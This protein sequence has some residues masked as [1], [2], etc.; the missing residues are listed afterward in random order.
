MAV[1]VIIL[2]TIVVLVALLL[3]GLILIQPSKSGGI[4]AA[5]GGIGESVFG[6]QAG[7]HLTKATVVLTTVFFVLALTLATMIGRGVQK[8]ET[9]R[10]IDADLR[11]KS[12]ESAQKPDEAAVAAGA[13]KASEPVT[14]GGAAGDKTE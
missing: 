13:E 11:L 1:L 6:A 5:F 14:A 3:I 12:V 8:S 4:G 10:G 7:S 2:Y 9:S